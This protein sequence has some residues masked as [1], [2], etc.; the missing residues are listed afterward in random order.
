MNAETDERCL[1]LRADRHRTGAHPLGGDDAAREKSREKHQVPCPL[2]PVVFE[3]FEAC[4]SDG[5]AQMTQI[6]R[7][8][9]LRAQKKKRRHEQADERPRDIPGPWLR[10]DVPHGDILPGNPG[11]S[12]TMPQEG[13]HGTVAAFLPVLSVT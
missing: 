9:E 11:L 4:G 3:V 13:E 12:R 2:A 7:D 10:E 8:A 6:A 5:R 1:R